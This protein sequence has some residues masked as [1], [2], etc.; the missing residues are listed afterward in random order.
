MDVNDELSELW[1][2]QPCASAATKEDLVRMVEKRTRQFD[3]FI[4]V[5]NVLESI[6][7]FAVTVIFAAMAA[8]APD[9]LQRAG[10]LI[11]AASG[12][13]IIAF[14]L[15]YRRASFPADPSQELSCYRRAL[16]ERYDR[17]IR[18]LKSVKYWYL[19]P[20]W[21]GLLT[22]SAGVILHAFRNGR[23]GWHDFIAPL[24]YTAF[25][26]GVWWLNEVYGVAHLQAERARVLTIAGDHAEHL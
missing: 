20:P 6:S 18:L 1:C 11:V 15:R 26:T 8:R 4:L 13:W 25:F 14:L 16:V 23:L 22:G 10:L 24:I 9:V 2:S 7:A 3:R 5:R 12:L 21:I 19:L 17:E